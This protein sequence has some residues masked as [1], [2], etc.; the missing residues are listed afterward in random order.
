MSMFLLTDSFG[1]LGEALLSSVGI[2]SRYVRHMV[3]D[4]KVGEPGKLYV[5]LFADDEILN[6]DL[7]ELGVE[8]KAADNGG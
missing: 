7:A 1:K 2:D 6:V 5:E 3:I 4:L 8:V